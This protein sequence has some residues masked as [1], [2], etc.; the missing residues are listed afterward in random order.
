MNWL[1]GQWRVDVSNAGTRGRHLGDWRPSGTPSLGVP[2]PSAGFRLDLDWG[3]AVPLT[4]ASRVT[5]P[6]TTEAGCRLPG[7]TPSPRRDSPNDEE[8]DAGQQGHR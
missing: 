6:T 5:A 3:Q 4:G 8:T 7:G 2:A 1:I